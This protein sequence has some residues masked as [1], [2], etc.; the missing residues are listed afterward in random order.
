MR[1]GKLRHY[2]TFQTRS[3][4][5]IG[6]DQST[7]WDGTTFQDWIALKPLSGRELIAGAAV[8]NEAT[9]LVQ[10][11]YRADVNAKMRIVFGARIFNIT[12]PPRNMDDRL[13]EMEFEVI[14]GLT[15]G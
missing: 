11:R 4:T 14:E 15:S 1:A 7:A 8:Q 13:K 5:R 3:L 2:V 9:H 6:A 12:S 10:M